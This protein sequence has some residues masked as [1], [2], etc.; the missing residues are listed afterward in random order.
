M[1]DSIFTQIVKGEIPCHKVY[2]DDQ[3]LA[4][5]DINPIT[6]G[7]MLVIPKEQ[8]EFIWDMNDA[9]Y[10]HLMAVVKKLGDHARTAMKTEYAGIQVVGVD[11]PH[12][13]IHVIPF[14]DVSEYH[15]VPDMSVEPNHGALAAIA[16]KL[17][18]T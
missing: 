1:E 6:P 2:E 14:N 5:L 13:H 7:H 3:V 17:A 12:A 16:R 11:V 15:N 8:V 18:T 4:F 9:L 10:Q